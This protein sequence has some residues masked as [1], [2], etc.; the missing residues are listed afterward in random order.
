[1]TSITPLSGTVIQNKNAWIAVGRQILAFY[2]CTETPADIGKCIDDWKKDRRV[3]EKEM[4]DGL[5]FMFGE[6]II[7]QHGGSWIWVSDSFGQTPAI[8]RSPEGPITYALDIV[9]KRLRDDSSATR[10]LRSIVDLYAKG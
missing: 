8:Q 6:L 10:E 4:I 5:G 1:M 9:S 2:G 7:A 3:A